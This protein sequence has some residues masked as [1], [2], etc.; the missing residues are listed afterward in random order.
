M[1]DM[2]KGK[3]NQDKLLSAFS[4]IPLHPNH[5]TF[6]SV[7]I[8]AGAFVL[9]GH[10]PVYSM[11][12]FGV[13]FFIDAL[14]GVVARAKNLTSKKGAFFDGVCDRIVEFFIILTIFYYFPLEKIDLILLVSILFFGTCMT[15]FTKAYAHHQGVLEEKDAKNLPGLFERAERVVLL[16]LMLIF[17]QY[18]P[19]YFIYLLAITALLSI[20]TFVQRVFLILK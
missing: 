7:L 10:E 17:L 20:L 9:F 6:L 1:I 15:S 5:I 11:L 16:F 2:L 8:A 13:S 14:D 19:G 4:F 18:L 3:I 12:L